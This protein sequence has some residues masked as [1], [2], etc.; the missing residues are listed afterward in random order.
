MV[1]P[2]TR[3]TEC[4]VTIQVGEAFGEV[5]F[6]VGAGE[7]LGR[8]CFLAETLRGRTKQGGVFIRARILDAA[9]PHGPPEGSG[10]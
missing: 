10:S 2:H 6:L 4:L 3:Q 8:C 5:D 9:Q 7:R 1:F